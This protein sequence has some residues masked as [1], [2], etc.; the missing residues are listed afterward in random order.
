MSFEDYAEA[1]AEDYRDAL[2]GLTMNSRVEINNLTLI[3]RENTE[4]GLAIAKALREHIKKV[5]LSIPGSRSRKA[6]GE[7]SCP[8][9][10]DFMLPSAL[11]VEHQEL[12][13]RRFN[14]LG[15]CQ[16]CIFWILLSRMLGH[17]IPYTSGRIC[18]APSWMRTLPSTTIPAARWMK[19]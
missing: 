1:V 10:Q 4:H 17:H 19:C 3:A 15:N 11:T 12:T 6:L 16:P 7:V 14:P 13:R 9:F 5:G 8:L 2:E 18:M